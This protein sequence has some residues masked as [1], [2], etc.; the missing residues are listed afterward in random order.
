MDRLGGV[1]VM[2]G[3][4]A[5]DPLAQEKYSRSKWTDTCPKNYTIR[6]YESTIR[7]GDL[8]MIWDVEVR[9]FEEL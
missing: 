4:G 5:I 3:D 7:E 2:S 1:A 6:Y 9:K 8:G